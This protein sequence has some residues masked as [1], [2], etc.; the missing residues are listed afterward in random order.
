M[1]AN[2]QYNSIIGMLNN[3]KPPVFKS[4]ILLSL[5]LIAFNKMADR[6]TIFIIPVNAIKQKPIKSKLFEELKK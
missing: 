6:I 1:I 4:C 2:Q 5:S 3:I